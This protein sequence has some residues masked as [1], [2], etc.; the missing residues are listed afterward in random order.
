M[1]Q[2]PSNSRKMW[3]LMIGVWTLG[4]TIAVYFLPAWKALIPAPQGREDLHALIGMLFSFGG[5]MGGA[6]GVLSICNHWLPK[7][8]L[9]E[10]ERQRILELLPYRRPIGLGAATLIAAFLVI[11]SIKYF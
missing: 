7:C 9:K 8:A 1:E 11:V 3:I 4:T 2:S 6:W 5:F 10:D